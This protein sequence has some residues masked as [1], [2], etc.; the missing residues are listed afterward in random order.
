MAA[1]ST[2]GRTNA[3]ATFGWSRARVN[4]TNPRTPRA[5][6]AAGRTEARTAAAARTVHRL[7]LHGSRR[8]DGM[9]RGISPASAQHRGSAR[10]SRSCAGA[11]GSAGISGRCMCTAIARRLQRTDRRLQT[12]PGSR[13]LTSRPSRTC[14]RR[15]GAHH[16]R[17]HQRRPV[18]GRPHPERAARCAT[19]SRKSALDRARDPSRSSRRKPDH[20]HTLQQGLVGALARAAQQPQRHDAWLTVSIDSTFVGPLGNPTSRRDRHPPTSTIPAAQRSHRLGRHPD[21]RLCEPRPPELPARWSRVGQARLLVHGGPIRLT[22]LLQAR[23]ASHLAA[24]RERVLGQRIRRAL[25]RTPRGPSGGVQLRLLVKPSL[26]PPS[27][28]GASMRRARSGTRTPDCQR[29]DAL[30]RLTSDRRQQG[31]AGGLE[32]V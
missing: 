18:S 17:R 5:R 16:H 23:P 20:P 13:A 12:H 27:T 1:G 7:V 30:V 28:P 32:G 2:S 4:R 14:M 6:A 9:P 3:Y 10:P 11:P 15:A 8:C 19:W 29:A 25:S 31:R 21:T 22:S 26:P 24:V